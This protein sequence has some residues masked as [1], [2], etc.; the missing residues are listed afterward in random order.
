MR[1]IFDRYLGSRNAALPQ[2]VWHC[3]VVGYPLVCWVSGD[4][5]MDHAAGAQ[6]DDDEHEYCAEEDI[7]RLKKVT[8]PD[9]AGV[10]A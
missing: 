4:A 6:L 8:G 7:V 5:K 10:V 9:L 3:V 1:R 2:M